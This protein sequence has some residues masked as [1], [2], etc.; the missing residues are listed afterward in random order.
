VVAE[1]DHALADRDALK[2]RLERLIEASMGVG[3][4]QPAAYSKSQAEA[5]KWAAFYRAI[6]D[7]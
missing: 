2:A 3:L 5:D 1:R 4:L 7:A 6:N